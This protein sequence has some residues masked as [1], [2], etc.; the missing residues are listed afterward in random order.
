[1]RDIY[2]MILAGG[3]GERLLPLTQH[4]AK[5]A[6]PFAG[7]YRIIDVTLSNCLNS[8]LRKI[9]VL[10]Q[11]KSHSL[12]RHIR[13]GWSIFNPELNEFIFSIPPQQ[14]IS[15]EWY[16]GTADAV[17]QNLFLLEQEH[18][19][20][21]LV[22]AGDHI[23]KMDYGDMFR[24]M[25]L[26]EADAVVGALEWPI[27]EARQFGVLGVDSTNRIIRFEEKPRIHSP[28]LTTQRK[29]L[30]LWAFTFFAQRNSMT[31]CAKMRE[32]PP[33]MISEKISFLI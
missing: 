20:F 15:T 32:W 24:Y 6:V 3:R 16:R 30:F 13:R 14:R 1:M 2:T 11:Y 12:D 8:G 18:P 28:Y 23:Y 22:L 9:A 7:K 4:R 29:R 26:M 17:Y 19:K 21:L 31:S 5:P 33:P 10:I 25:Q 27:E